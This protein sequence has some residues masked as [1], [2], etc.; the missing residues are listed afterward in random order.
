MGRPAGSPN[1]TP[2]RNTTA[3]R[4]A[5]KSQLGPLPKGYHE[6]LHILIERANTASPL[7]MF[8]EEQKEEL[9]KDPLAVMD[10]LGKLQEWQKI[11]LDAANKAAPFRHARLSAS[12]VNADEGDEEQEGVALSR[13][14][15]IS[16]SAA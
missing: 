3:L 4:R 10:I 1:K 14:R 6:P 13:L 16:G 2:R 11:T 9:S 7:D 8:T 5:L 15:V 12:E